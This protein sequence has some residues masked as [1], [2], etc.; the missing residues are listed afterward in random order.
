MNIAGHHGLLGFIVE[1]INH[2]PL[3]GGSNSSE[4]VPEEFG[5]GY[6]WLHY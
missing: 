2:P 4:L 5:E 3:E 1:L 6:Y